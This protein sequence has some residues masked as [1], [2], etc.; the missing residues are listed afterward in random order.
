V[1]IW[2]IIKNK[3]PTNC[4]FFEVEVKSRH[5][6]DDSLEISLLTALWAGKGAKCW[7]AFSGHGWKLQPTTD[8][9]V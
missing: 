1:H 6:I 2:L 5:P 4:I 9:C 7:A 3:A 8:K